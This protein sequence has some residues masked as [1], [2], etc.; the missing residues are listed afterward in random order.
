MFIH[1]PGTWQQYVQRPE[2]RG[3]SVTLLE[4]KYRQELFYY[5]MALSE[6]VDNTTTTSA[7]ASAGGGGSITSTTP[8][9]VITD[10][11]VL[12]FVAAS[13]ITDN[14]QKSAVNTLVTSLK[15]YSIWSS[16]NAIYPFVGGT[17]STHKW[18]LKDPRDLN[19]AYRLSFSGGWTHNSNGI[20]GNASN[21]YADTF[22]SNYITQVRALGVYTRNT[23]A[24]SNGVYIGQ[25]ET[26][27]TTDPEGTQA[28]SEI[29]IQDNGAQMSTDISQGPN[30]SYVNNTNKSGFYTISSGSLTTQ[31]STYKN[32]TLNSSTLVNPTAVNQ[33]D[34]AI[35]IGALRTVT[36][37][38][39]V[40]VPGSDNIVQY[41][42]QNI[43]FAFIGNQFLSAAQMG[44]L[45]TA[46]Q[47][48]QT[49]LGRQV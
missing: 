43:A 33:V 41:T 19:A 47:A 44:N 37:L 40:F 1:N 14:T 6:A 15:G 48:Y 38:D 32:G 5:Q 39:S 16:L 24:T 4:R 42:N 11:D 20:T 36:S 12:A 9:V 25:S 10:S 34:R 30:T 22:F 26:L 13:G 7:A 8:N 49:T 17:A 21:T 29:M 27:D 23:T 46:V 31:T 28:F 35:T 2:H 18:N 45:Y 3:V